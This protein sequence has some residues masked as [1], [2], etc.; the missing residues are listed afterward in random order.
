[1]T[2]AAAT[3]LRASSCTLR[4]ERQGHATIAVVIEG[5]DVGELG[6]LPMRC[7]E[8]FM[9]DDGAVTLLIDASNARGATMRVS[10]QWARWL[11]RN[12]GRFASV[13]MQ[14]SSP[15]VRV[16]ADFVRR[17]AQLESLM[18]VERV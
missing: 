2:L 8:A 11:E 12:R 15:Y 5:H 1:M 3:E 18:Q 13:R 6:D 10:Q 17:F 14:V 9:P 7:I 16:T 4:I